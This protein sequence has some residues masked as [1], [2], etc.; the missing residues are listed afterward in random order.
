MITLTINHLPVSVK[1]GTTILEAARF[2]GI[3]IP[4]LC[5]LKNIN[6]I[7]ACRVCL[8]EI[9]GSPCL[10]AA[11]NTIA[12]ENMV[13]FT[14]SKAVREARRDIVSMLLSQHD[15][16][17]PT[18][19][20]NGNCAL[21]SLA[22]ELNLIQLPYSKHVPVNNWNLSFPL[23]REE[24]KCINCLRCVNLCSKVQ[25]MNV[26]DLLGTGSRAHVGLTS[27]NTIEE[28]DCTLCG[29]C[30]THC[31]VGALHERNDIQKV[32]D[33]IDNKK[34]TTVVQIAPAVRS[35]W[36]EQLGLPAD[37][38]TEQRMVAAIKALGFDYVLDTNYTADLTIMEEGSEFI[39]R[40]T[41][42]EKYSWPM[43]TSCCPGW[44][45]FVK[46]QYPE[47]VK[48]L[49]TAKSPQQMFGAIIKTY[50]A[51]KTGLDPKNI[52]SVSIMPC[53]AKKYE[54]DVENM[55]D[56]HAGR[57]V[58]VVLTTREMAQ[59]IR[60][61]YINIEQLPE[62]DFDSP[63]GHGTGAGVI[64]GTTGGVMEAALRSAHYLLSGENPEPDAFRAVRIDQ[65]WETFAVDVAGT[66]VKVAVCSGLK[67]TRQLMEAV[68][69][70]QLD[71][72][73]VEIMAC[74]GG[75]AG[76]GGQPIHINHELGV[77]R[78]QKLYSL[79]ANHKLRF[80]HEN[81]DILQTYEEFLGKPLGEKSH[82]LLHTDQEKWN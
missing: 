58:D 73:F 49:S 25:N 50:F 27:A 2:I 66:N 53:T 18:C 24:S 41:H 3:K 34:I 38:S 35:A 62:M 65:G 4:T 29:Q 13:V 20:R 6:E 52:C 7:G 9:E 16:H 30:I 55:T 37:K 11:C 10:R 22:Q 36:A 75:C 51:Q 19:T 74:P 1:Q 54:A 47:Y 17:C 79:D 82:H 60:S 48:N 70:G 14:N 8:V 63:L 77:A 64:F 56:A 57:D 67:N 81:P 12:E 71:C 43:F 69:K 32:Y 15:C 5:Y 76:G 33:A 59:M 78:S 46:S 72:D 23:I 80:S 28:S 31:P 21:Q 42:R 26:W 45:R 39:E 44:V 61:A 68:R 40:F